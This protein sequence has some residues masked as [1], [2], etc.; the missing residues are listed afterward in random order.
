MTYIELRNFIENRMQMSH[1]YQPVMLLTLLRHGGTAAKRD[2]AASILSHDESQLEYYDQIVSG[3]VGKVLRNHRVVSWKDGRFQLD[4]FNKLSSHQKAQL[5]KLCERNL[6]RETLARISYRFKRRKSS[7]S[8][9]WIPMKNSPK[10]A[11]SALTGSKRI[12]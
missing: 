3:M 8:G 2:I 9:S 10:S 6:K 7:S 11:Y 1:V 4:G 5:T 12:S